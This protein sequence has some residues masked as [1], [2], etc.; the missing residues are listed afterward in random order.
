MIHAQILN[1][2]VKNIIVTDE[3]TPMDLF[4]AECDVIV[5]IDELESM[6]NIGWT[7]DGEEFA[8][9]AGEGPKPIK[10]V[11]VDRLKEYKKR[12]V[13]LV[14]ELK[15][16]N[17]LA[18]ITLEESAKM[19][20]DFSDVLLMLREGMFPTAI[21]RLQQKQPQGFVTQEMLNNWIVKIKNYL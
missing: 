1:G 12:G 20:D 9:P 14:D 21:Y 5:R 8:P 10:D 13:Q 16:D 6:P 18:G 19:I 3:N 15:A 17:T 4:E 11:I 2:I 7:F